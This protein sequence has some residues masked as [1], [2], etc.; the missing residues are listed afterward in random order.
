M[1][2]YETPTRKEDRMLLT[3]PLDPDELVILEEEDGELPDRDERIVR[4]VGHL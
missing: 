4:A 3:Q 1:A 2:P